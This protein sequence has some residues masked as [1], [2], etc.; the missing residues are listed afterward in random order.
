AVAR[1][2]CSH[3]ASAG[4][5]AGRSLDSTTRVPG[6]QLHDHGEI[7]RWSGRVGNGHRVDEVLLEAGLHGGLDLL[8]GSDD[9]LDLV[10]CL[11]RQERDERAGARGIPR[12]T[13]AIERRV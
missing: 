12:R 13:D 11:A 3:R 5:A 7:R 8:D 2:S 1:E 10:P 4:L 9:P 6:W